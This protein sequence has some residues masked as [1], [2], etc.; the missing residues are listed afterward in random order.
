MTVP[1]HG[2]EKESDATMDIGLIGLRNLELEMEGRL[3]RDGEKKK[4]R[5]RLEA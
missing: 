4:T 3:K 1:G 5:R 2:A